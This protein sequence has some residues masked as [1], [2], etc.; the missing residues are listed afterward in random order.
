MPPSTLAF[1][2]GI[3]TPGPNWWMKLNSEDWIDR[4]QILRIK[5]MIHYKFEDQTDGLLKK[6]FMG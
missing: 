3:I 6:F 4:F 1:I 5:L 2:N